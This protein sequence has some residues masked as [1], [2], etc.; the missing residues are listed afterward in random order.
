MK[1]NDYLPVTKKE[2]HRG[3]SDDINHYLQHVGAKLI[4]DAFK[5]TWLRREQ[6]TMQNDPCC[7]MI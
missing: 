1:D 6:C 2:M 5:A 7:H 3:D 4:I